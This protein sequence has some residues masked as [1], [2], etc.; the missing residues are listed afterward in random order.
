MIIHQHES[1]EYICTG[2]GFKQME[3]VSE[4]YFVRIPEENND[5]TGC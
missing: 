3:G 1:D 4:M 2:K 5:K